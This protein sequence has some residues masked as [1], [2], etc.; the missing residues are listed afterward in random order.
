MFSIQSYL[1]F[2]QQC[3][4]AMVY[5]NTMKSIIKAMAEI[6]VKA[7]HG[8]IYCCWLLHFV[9]QVSLSLSIQSLGTWVTKKY[10]GNGTGW[11]GPIKKRITSPRWSHVSH[12]TRTGTDTWRHCSFNIPQKCSIKWS[13][14]NFLKG[15]SKVIC[16]MG[17]KGRWCNLHNKTLCPSP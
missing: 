17:L 9:G 2:K 15:T 10:G 6:L 12:I 14:R 5:K 8:T 3:I 16:H 13:V 4:Y 11:V 7:S 1:Y